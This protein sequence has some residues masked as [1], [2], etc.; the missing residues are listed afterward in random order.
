M[1]TLFSLAIG[2]GVS[3]F[4]GYLAIFAVKSDAILFTQMSNQMAAGRSLQH[5]ADRVCNAKSSSIS[6]PSAS[7]IR[8]Q[9]VALPSGQTAKIVFSNGQTLYYPNVN[10]TAG[11]QTFGKGLVSLTFALTNQM[12]EVTAVYKYRKPKGYGQTEQEKMNGTFVT[13]IY[14]RNG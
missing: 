5:I 14:P 10:T 11:R 7:E 9:S 2:A 13:R 3:V 4:V 1:S 12:V 8:F 6:V